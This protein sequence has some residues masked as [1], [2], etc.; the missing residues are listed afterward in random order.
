MTTATT[1]DAGAPAADSPAPGL[2]LLTG[3]QFAA[4][5][6]VSFGGPLALGA[7]YAPQAVD[8]VT[9]A[10]GFAALLAPVIFAI[11][12][13][14]WLG[15]SRGIAGPGGLYAFVEAAAGRRVAQVQGALWVFS[16]ALYL[17]Y[18]TAYVV[19]DV[20]PA[21]SPRFNSYR[22]GLEVAL[23][24]GIA[25]VVLAGR[26]MTVAVL[27]VIA[28]G[29]LAL[30]GLLDVV[31]V[32]HGSSGSAFAPHGHPHATAVAA[33]SIAL[34]F[35]CGSLPLFLGGEVARPHRT[36]RRV[37]PSV[38]VLTA[39]I[40]VLAVLPIAVDPAFAQAAIPGMSLVHVDV[41]ATAATA[42]GLGVAASIVGVMVLE[43]VAVTRLVHA[44]SGR[45]TTSIARWLAVPLVA[46]GPISLINPNAFYDDLLKPSLVA[47]WL[48]QLI[49]VA[50]YP[51]YARARG[52][53]RAQHVVLAAAASGVMVF[54]LWS[55]LSSSSST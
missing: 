1:A 45:S 15:Y 9:S 27:G 36:I 41:N 4:I 7:L 39:A 3:W 52:R 13:V 8:D 16:Y 11:P 38:Y 34:L 40:V 6:V 25:A 26:R 20:L 12:M 24:V 14:I 5:A 31:A 43:Y 18:T 51:F 53:I 17:I 47:L 37:L 49:V 21:V 44:V 35:V 46:A 30:A 28:V 55:T 54:G 29:Q 2:R 23:P 19:Y 50:V 32:R 42:I 10:A 48:S 22:S 33:G